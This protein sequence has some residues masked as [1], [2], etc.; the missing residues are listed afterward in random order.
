M[1][2]AL[3]TGS[4]GQDGHFLIKLLL[5]KQHYKIFGMIRRS[6]SLNRERIEEFR[7]KITLV[8]GD[9]TDQTSLI[10]ILNKIKK[11]CEFE[12]LEVYNLAAQSHVQISAVIPHFTTMV[13]AVGV[14]NILDAIRLTDLIGKTRFYQASSSEMFGK[15][16]EVPQTEKTPFW[17]RSVYSVSKLYGHWITKNYRESYGMHASNGILFNH[18]SEARSF[19]FVTKKITLGVADIVAGK[20]E[21]ISLGNLDAKR[22]WMFAGDA[23]EA[24]YLMLQQDEPGDY[25]VGFGEN[26]S[27]REFV[28]EA[29]LC[30]GIEIKWK[31]EGLEEVGYDAKT[32]KVLVKVD[33]KFYRLAEVDELLSDSSHARSK[34][35]WEPKVTFKELVKRMV[36]YDLKNHK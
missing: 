5:E 18:E 25:V 2:V 19:N 26:H 12:R 1:K 30:V 31:G 13:D 32:D 29:F 23:V 10:E 11:E 27:V 15:V 33:P 28:Q 14:L 24:M 17:P 8:Y 4:S 7:D 16:Q 20:A 34:L 22:D 6:S 21:H 36:D 35:G 3:I 9:M